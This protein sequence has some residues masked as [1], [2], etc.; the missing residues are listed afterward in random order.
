LNLTDFL[1][2]NHPVCQES[3]MLRPCI[4]FVAALA[5]T[6]FQIHAQSATPGRDLTFQVSSSQAW[7]DTGLD[8]HPGDIVKVS[9]SPT[10]GSAESGLP[11]CDPA[12]VAGGVA[13]ASRLPLPGSPAGALIA[14]LHDEKSVP[15]LLGADKE[16]KIEDASHLFLGMNASSTPVHFW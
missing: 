12:G 15:V 14:R 2:D 11:V 13:D 16:L 10:G 7:I 3:N 1:K 5:V 8:L 4:V 9:A 6:S